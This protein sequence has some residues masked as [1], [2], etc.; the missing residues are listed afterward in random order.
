MT[1]SSAA[2]SSF[3]MLTY[4]GFLISPAVIGWSADHIGLSRPLTLLVP[5][6]LLATAFVGFS[7][8]RTDPEEAAQ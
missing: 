3:G 7:A 4:A 8:P 1:A 5:A 6:L 2:V